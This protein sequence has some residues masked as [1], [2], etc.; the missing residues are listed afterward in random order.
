MPSSLL[1]KTTLPTLYHSLPCCCSRTS[2]SPRKRVK[3]DQGAAPRVTQRRCYADVKRGYE[4]RDNTNWP[5]RHV[6]SSPSWTPSPYEIFDLAKDGTYTKHKFYELVKI[7]HPDRHSHMSLEG[8]T[9]HERL[10]RYR[11]VVQAHEI[12]SD[13]DKRRAY[14]AAGVGWGSSRVATRYSRGFSNGHGKT[15]GYGPNDDSSIFQNATWEDW[16]RWY[17][18]H[19]NPNKQEYSGTFVHPNA[20]ASFVILLAVISGVF[21]A[22]R[23]GQYS[24]QLEEKVRE[25]TAETRNFLDAR[26]N[27]YQQH[28][29][30]V[31]GR[32]KHFLEKRDPSK[33]GLKDEEEEV[34]R[35]HFSNSGVMAPK[36]RL[37][38]PDAA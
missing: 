11:L 10:E 22:T 30:G 37:K 20:F 12:L 33:Y 4:F 32:I 38:T 21:Q 13:P 5:C 6:K 36:P 35:S 24:G 8:I 23:A 26:E 15:Y 31:D 27:H 1:K 2:P 28:Q 25:H 17:R 3:S 16:E 14:D 18:R 34:Y 19:D 29:L 9:H 7:Y